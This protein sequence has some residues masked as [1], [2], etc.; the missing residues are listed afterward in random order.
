MSSCSV[1]TGLH[2]TLTSVCGSNASIFA[3]TTLSCISGFEVSSASVGTSAPSMA[4][5]APLINSSQCRQ[6]WLRLRRYSQPCFPFPLPLDL[7]AASRVHLYACDRPE[8]VQPGILPASAHALARTSNE[9]TSKHVSAHGK[10]LGT[11]AFDCLLQLVP[12]RPFKSHWTSNM[13]CN[14]NCNPL[15]TPRAATESLVAIGCSPVGLEP[16]CGP[17]NWTC[18]L[19]SWPSQRVLCYPAFFLCI[20]PQSFNSRNGSGC[21][22]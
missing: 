15:T 2:P 6:V 19:Y 21:P 11:T 1:K 20:H 3:V 22:T 10:L 7:G 5:S 14:C 16:F 13:Q 17:C 12:T 8:M 9:P 4:D 18:K